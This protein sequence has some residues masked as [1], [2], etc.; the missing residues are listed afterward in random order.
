MHQLNAPSP[1]LNGNYKVQTLTYGSG[2]DKHRPEYGEEATIITNTIDGIPFLDNWEGMSGWYRERFWGFDARELPVN[3]RVWYPEGEGPFPLALI[4]HG[5]HSM[6]DF[7]D[8]GYAYLG[9]LMASRGF[10]F[11][12][13]DQNFINSQLVR[14]P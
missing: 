9:E 10:I 3:G 7:S 12:S 5:N 13:V 14:Y 11:A 1:S 6:H 8:E 4:V 2:T